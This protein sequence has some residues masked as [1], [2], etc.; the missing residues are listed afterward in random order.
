VETNPDLVE[1]IMMA[2][3][4]PIEEMYIFLMICHYGIPLK[5][6]SDEKGAA[7]TEKQ[8]PSEIQVKSFF[9]PNHIHE[10][11]APPKWYEQFVRKS[12]GIDPPYARKHRRFAEGESDSDGYGS[13]FS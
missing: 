3:G 1:D 4:W 12:Y 7:E 5:G 13:G 10:N 8:L 6:N 9:F 2:L 11:I